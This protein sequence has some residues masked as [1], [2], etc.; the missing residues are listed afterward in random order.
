L[1]VFAIAIA[2]TARNCSHQKP[3]H[4]KGEN[5]LFQIY[6]GKNLKKELQLFAHA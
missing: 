4:I 1:F 3:N 6:I 2:R 5:K